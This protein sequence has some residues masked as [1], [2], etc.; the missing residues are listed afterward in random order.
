MFESDAAPILEL[1]WGPIQGRF[2]ADRQLRRLADTQKKKLAATLQEIPLP[3]SWAWTLKQRKNRSSEDTALGFSWE[4]E[5]IGGKG[6]LLF[7]PVSRIAALVQLYQKKSSDHHSVFAEILASF[8]DHFTDPHSLWALFDI[9]ARIPDSFQLT[10]YRFA[11]GEFEMNFAA[12]GKTLALHRWS[13][14]SVLLRKG[15]LARFASERFDAPNEEIQPTRSGVHESVEWGLKP[16]GWLAR[17]P[18]LKIEPRMDM[19]RLWH[20]REKNRLLAVRL[21]GKQI[22]ASFLDGICSGYDIVDDRSKQTI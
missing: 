5:N 3:E 20:I 9:R 22:D 10:R 21:E 13:P 17:I 6:V 19:A 4:G 7:S 15:D 8:R 11:P 18:F 14:A 16:K 12:K 1:K 2:S